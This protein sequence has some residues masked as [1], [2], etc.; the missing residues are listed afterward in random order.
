MVLQLKV[1]IYQSMIGKEIISGTIINVHI[2][3]KLVLLV[4]VKEHLLM[5]Y[6]ILVFLETI[7]IVPLVHKYL[8]FL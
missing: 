1:K 2:V 5:V 4:K 8:T 3:M 7:K 6:K